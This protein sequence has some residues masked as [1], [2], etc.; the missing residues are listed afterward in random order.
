MPEDNPVATLETP[1]ETP[2]AKPP[3]LEQNVHIADVGPCRKHIRVIVERKD[4]DAK[5]KDKFNEMMPEAQ[6]P[7]YRPG[8]APRKLIERK[9]FKEVSEQIK[10]ELLLQSLE[11]L[12]EDN[13]LNP[14]SQPNIDPFK[15]ELPEQGPLTY[16]FEIEVAPEFDLPPYKS[17]KLK[18]PVKEISPTE[19]EDAKVKYLRRFGE[20]VP[21]DGPV[22][23]D[24]HI[25]ADVVI[26]LDGKQLSEFKDLALKVDPLLSFKDGMA[27]EFGAKLTG[28]KVG[29]TR[30]VAIQLSPALVDQ[31]LRG[32][33]AQGTFTVKKV[34]QVKMPELT[35]QFREAIGWGDEE[36]LQKK[37][38]GALEKQLEYE[39]RRVAR[40]QVL[41]HIAAAAAWELPSDLLHR[42]ARRNLS[43]RVLELRN[44]GFS[45]EDIRARSNILQQD[46]LDS[47]AR[48][49]KEHFVLQKIAEVE[50]IEV[51]DNDVNEEIDNIA[52]QT[53]ESP[54]KV[55]AR[56][57]RED[58]IETLMT[59]ILERKALDLVLNTATYEDVPFTQQGPATEAVEGSA[60]GVEAPEPPP[61]AEAEEEEGE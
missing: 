56:L 15:I 19:V 7:G 40:E 55:R 51:D 32:R 27:P 60:S 10:G 57:E 14:I 36:E 28:A 2:D 22:A 54:R 4:I 5:L 11:Q 13:K 39:Q 61:L 16:E 52:A 17:L 53:D 37:F 31:N 6:V 48:G 23:I 20:L 45:E 35:P 30:Q 26:N 21:K 29:D 46:I 50:K 38:R 34:Q 43:R 1:A 49:L 24:D 58:M 47:T 9:F 59:E 3:R 25:I 44:A 33:T 12:A 18:R 42:Q 8:K 41:Q